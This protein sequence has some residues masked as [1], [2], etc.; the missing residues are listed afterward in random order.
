MCIRDRLGVAPMLG[1][2]FLPDDDKPSETGRVVVLSQSL[3]QKRFNSDPSILNQ[4]LTLS[5]VT[6]TVVGVMPAGFEFPIQN[7]P[8]EL[9]TTIAGD[10]AGKTPVTAQRGAHFLQVIGRLK[11]GVSVDQAQ[12]EFTAI[13]AR[14]E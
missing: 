2:T 13:A 7:D 10:A 3:F 5:G 4:T 1:R 9:W 6:F 12:A 8:I 11:P 14:L